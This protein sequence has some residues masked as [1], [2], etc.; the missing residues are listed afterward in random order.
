MTDTQGPLS[1]NVKVDDA[2]DVVTVYGIDFA[3]ELLRTFANVTPRG[4]WFRVLSAENGLCTVHK[5]STQ[6]IRDGK[7][8]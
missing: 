6:D 3:G 5:A 2:R 8:Q 4:W 1:A 7:I